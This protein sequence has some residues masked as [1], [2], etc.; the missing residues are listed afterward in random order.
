MPRSA[1]VEIRDPSGYLLV[2][3]PARI[4][5]GAVVADLPSFPPDT[6]GSIQLCTN[7]DGTTHRDPPKLKDVPTEPVVMVVQMG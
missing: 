7:E 4:Q 3:V 5:G 2:S 1:W 6:R